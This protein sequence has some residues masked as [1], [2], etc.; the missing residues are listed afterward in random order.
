MAQ[1]N[2]KPMNRKGVMFKLVDQRNV[3]LSPTTGKYGYTFRIKNSKDK[4]VIN[5]KVYLYDVKNKIKY[6]S[7][8]NGNGLVKFLVDSGSTYEIDIEKREVVKILSTKRV[9]Y[10]SES[11]ELVYDN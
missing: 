8:T 4:A 9:K 10:G 6:Q 5:T 2:I 1:D 11:V 3:E 7:I